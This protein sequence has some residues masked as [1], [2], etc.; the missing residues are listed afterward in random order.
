VNIYIRTGVI[1]I[2]F[3]GLLTLSS[4]C[5]QQLTQTEIKYLETRE[6]DGPYDEIYD[7]SLN[8]MFSLGL[9][10]VHT[11]KQSGIV[12]GQSGDHVQRVSTH[13]LFRPLYPVKKVTLM[14]KDKAPN[15]TQIRMKVLVNEQQQL[16]RKLMTKIW[17]RIEREAMLEAKPPEPTPSTKPS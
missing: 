11:D 8:A 16:D 2:V 17:Q 6:L 14:V 13:P 5:S 15:L 1:S 7:A 9:S 3:L 10:I 12:T 4:G